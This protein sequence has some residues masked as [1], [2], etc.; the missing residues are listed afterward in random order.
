M[1]YRP[2]IACLAFITQACA[3]DIIEMNKCRSYSHLK[4]CVWHFTESHVIGI[5]ELKWQSWLE[6]L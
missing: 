2:Q 6:I 3:K 5:I 1:I 4:L